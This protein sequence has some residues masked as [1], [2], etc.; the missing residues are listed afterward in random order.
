MVTLDQLFKRDYGS[1]KIG[2]FGCGCWF[3]WD[4][5]DGL[6][7]RLLEHQAL[8]W[9]DCARTASRSSMAALWTTRRQRQPSATIS[10]A[11]ALTSYS[12]P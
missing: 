11:K 8:L 4:Q 3:Y 10:D 9:N 5:F 1:A 7:Q 2:F 6:K 12:A